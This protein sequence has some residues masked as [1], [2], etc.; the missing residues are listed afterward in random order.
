MVT[1]V[2]NS[3]PVSK[4]LTSCSQLDGAFSIWSVLNIKP[5]L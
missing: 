4:E 5:H 3:V 2:E 1:L